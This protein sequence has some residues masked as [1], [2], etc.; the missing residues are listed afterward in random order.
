M[1]TLKLLFAAVMAGFVVAQNTN[2]SSESD[3]TNFDVNQ[4]NLS[5]RGMLCW[6]SP[7][8]RSVLTPVGSRM[9]Q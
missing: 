7:S 2:S 1:L 8:P 3:N 6:L 4:I 5:Q 9:V